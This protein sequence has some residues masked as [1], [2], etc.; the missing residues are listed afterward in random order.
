[1]LK[2][3]TSDYKKIYLAPLILEN[4]E[5]NISRYHGNGEHSYLQ[6]IKLQNEKGFPLGMMHGKKHESLLETF[7]LKP[8]AYSCGNTT[9][10]RITIDSNGDIYKCHRIVGRKEY[11]L[12]I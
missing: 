12:E 9:V 5:E 3:L 8:N 1:M 10:N 7:G 4:A 6:A 11:V 2:K